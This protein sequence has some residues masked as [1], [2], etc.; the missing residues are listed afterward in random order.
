M[1]F[2][3]GY[4]VWVSCVLLDML[5]ETKDRLMQMSFSFK[6]KT[7]WIRF[8]RMWIPNWESCYNKKWLK[9]FLISLILSF[10]EGKNREWKPKQADTWVLKTPCMCVQL[11][12][13]Q[14]PI[15]LHSFISREKL[16]WKSVLLSP[17]LLGI[18]VCNDFCFS[19]TWFG[20]LKR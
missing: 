6:D 5:I 7:G 17:L 10:L 19:F 11:P 2:M 12:S 13:N 4:L 3:D 9:I 14:F 15:V 18:Q 8:L 1:F 16:F 20:T